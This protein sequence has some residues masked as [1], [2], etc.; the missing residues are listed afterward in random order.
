MFVKYELRED[1][2]ISWA[3]ISLYEM[4]TCLYSST[5]SM[6]KIYDKIR[7]YTAKGQDA[8]ADGCTEIAVFSFYFSIKI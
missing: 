2:C 7:T 8:I 1:G 3:H 5:L 6:F 4:K